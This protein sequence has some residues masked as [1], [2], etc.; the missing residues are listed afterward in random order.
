MCLANSRNVKQE[1]SQDDEKF[2]FHYFSFLNNT[3][4]YYSYFKKAPVRIATCGAF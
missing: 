2:L 4:S 1:H 3:L